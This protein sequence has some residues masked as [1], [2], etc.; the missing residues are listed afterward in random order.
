MLLT[1]RKRGGERRCLT[2]NDANDVAYETIYKTET[3]STL[4]SRR[5]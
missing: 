1:H 4:K 3:A 2:A 5:L